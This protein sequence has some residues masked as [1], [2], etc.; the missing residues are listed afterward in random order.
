MSSDT[1]VPSKLERIAGSG[2]QSERITKSVLRKELAAWVAEHQADED[3]EL[4]VATR[5]ANCLEHL[6]TRQAEKGKMT[7]E[8]AHLL[9]PLFLEEIV[10]NLLA[11]ERVLTSFTYLA[12]RILRRRTRPTTLP[13]SSTSRSSTRIATSTRAGYPSSRSPSSRLVRQRA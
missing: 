11:P 7:E 13:S 10:R 8:M 2:P 4:A 1:I 5:L 9:W 3:F 12:C 6:R